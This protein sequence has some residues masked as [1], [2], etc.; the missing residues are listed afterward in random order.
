MTGYILAQPSRYIIFDISLCIV[1][2]AKYSLIFSIFPVFGT[3]TI[4]SVRIK[5]GKIKAGKVF[6]TGTYVTYYLS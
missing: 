3:E 6:F 5:A 2:F 1:E 4:K